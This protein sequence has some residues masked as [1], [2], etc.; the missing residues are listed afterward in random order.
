MSRIS[1]RSF[2]G[3]WFRGRSLFD[4]RLLDK[5][6][7]LKSVGRRERRQPVALSN[8]VEIFGG[9]LAFLER[10]SL[11][12]RDGPIGNTLQEAHLVDHVRIALV[13]G[14]QGATA[15]SNGGVDTRRH[16]GD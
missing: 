2:G 7:G 10:V 6:R 3:G 8:V 13:M 14:L 1:T 12:P 5:V 15:F 11:H 4:R 9:H 16:G